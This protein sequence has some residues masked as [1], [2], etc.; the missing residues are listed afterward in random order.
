M[1]TLQLSL[2][3]GMLIMTG[4][5]LLLFRY[6]P[7]HPALGTYLE[8]IN[9]TQTTAGPMGTDMEEGLEDRLGLWLQRHVGNR[10]SVPRDELEILRIPVHKFLAQKA[11]FGLV[12]L[13]IAPVL[14]AL[15]WAIGVSV[16]IGL[17]V[18]GSLALAIGLSFIPDLNARTDAQKAREEFRYVLSTYMDLVALERRAASSPSPRQAMA[19]AATVG[20]HWVF[21][22][23]DEELAHSRLSG[24]PP[25]DRFRQLGET[26]QVNELIELGNIMRIAGDESASVY[27]TLSQR[28][29]AMRKAHLAKELTAAN[30]VSTKR[31][32]PVALL[33]GVFMLMLLAPALLGLL[34]T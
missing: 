31:S 21:R 2:L 10:L 30:E 12:G 27:E 29:K 28:S 9:S 7:K 3:A 25:W 17:P 22:R 1:T 34:G 23:L 26:Y 19:Q 16:P 11:L 8:A 14:G 33:G 32:A 5:V 18:V 15:L 13:M 20:D 6:A 24:I 4:P